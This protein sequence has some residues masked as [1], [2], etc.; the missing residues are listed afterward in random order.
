MAGFYTNTSGT[1]DGFL[2][3]G[4]TFINLAVPGASSTMALGVNDHD[5]VVGT[6]TVGTGSSAVTHGFTWSPAT[7]SRRVDDPQGMAPPRSTA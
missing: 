6:Y 2:K 5:E 3:T 4:G 1:T 7:A